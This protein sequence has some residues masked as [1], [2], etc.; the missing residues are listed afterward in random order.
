MRVPS[1]W[2]QVSLP[3]LASENVALLLFLLLSVLRL[4]RAAVQPL[5]QQTDKKTS[6]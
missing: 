5:C 3:S 4:G 1:G 6:T 2:K